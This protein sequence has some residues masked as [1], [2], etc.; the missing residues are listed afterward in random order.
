MADVV[1]AATDVEDD[2]DDDKEVAEA[3]VVETNAVEEA[4]DPVTDDE[5]DDV[6]ASFVLVAGTVGTDDGNRAECVSQY[7]QWAA[8]SGSSVRAVTPM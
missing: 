4:A 6:S 5:A 7:T 1:A 8:S 3:A 2:D